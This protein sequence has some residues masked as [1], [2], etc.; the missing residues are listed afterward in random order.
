MFL[1]VPIVANARLL[2]LFVVS[3]CFVYYVLYVFRFTHV[4]S[5]TFIGKCS[6]GW[7][8]GMV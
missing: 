5:A 8:S 7:M 2:Y 3:G 6:A 1:H 4:F